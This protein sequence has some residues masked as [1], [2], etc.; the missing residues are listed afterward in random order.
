MREGSG[1]QDINPEMAAVFR[2]YGY[3]VTGNGRISSQDCL[4][5][6]TWRSSAFADSRRKDGVLESFWQFPEDL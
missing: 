5:R 1:E 4:G 2:L 3:L 6:L